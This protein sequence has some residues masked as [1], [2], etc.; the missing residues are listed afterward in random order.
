MH[1]ILSYPVV[2]AVDCKNIDKLFLKYIWY[3]NAIG[4]CRHY[5]FQSYLYGYTEQCIDNVTR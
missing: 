4:S 3:Q 5:A 2:A 1:I